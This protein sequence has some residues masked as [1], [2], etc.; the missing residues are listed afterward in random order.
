MSI[1]IRITQKGLRKKTLPLE[2]ITGGTLVYGSGDGTKFEEGNLEGEEIL[3]YHPQHVSRGFSITWT[4]KEKTFVDLRA[5]NP[6]SAEGLQDFFDTIARISEYWKCEIEMDGEIIKAEEL[7]SRIPEIQ[8]FNRGVLGDICTDILTG[9]KSALTLFSVMFPLTL[10]KKEAELFGEDP[11]NVKMDAF[12]DWLHERQTMD[13]YFARPQFYRTP[14][15]ILG[16]YAVTEGC[17]TIFPVKAQVPF[18]MEDPETGKALKCDQFEVF[19]YSTTMEKMIGKCNFDEFAR[20]VSSQAERFDGD[21][22]LFEGI[23]L[24]TLQEWVEE[25][26]KH[27]H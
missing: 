8:E 16:G 20:K 10:G 12:A 24:E 25:S 5:V 21:K 14:N 4:P 19:F 26:N 9:E 15:G 6:D 18:G 2:V 3:L 1:D 13:A 17:R 7:K 11:E 27:K 22:F 23:P